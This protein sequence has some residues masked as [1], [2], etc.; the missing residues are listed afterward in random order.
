MNTPN[1]LAGRLKRR[2]SPRRARAA[3][4]RI[5]PNAESNR[6]QGVGTFSLIKLHSPQYNPLPL[7]AFPGN[8]IN[9]REPCPIQW[10]NA[11]FHL[12]MEA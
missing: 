8:S 4:P 5:A 2:V 12:S 9:G 10:I 3:P 7:S 11:P 1:D 6:K